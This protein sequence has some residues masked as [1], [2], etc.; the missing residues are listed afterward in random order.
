MPRR[1]DELE[2]LGDPEQHGPA[3]AGEVPD[4]DLD[5]GVV[6]DHL[7]RPPRG[8]VRDEVLDLRPRSRRTR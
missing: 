3:V 7:Q 8:P 6:P 2:P 5:L 1:V 4:L